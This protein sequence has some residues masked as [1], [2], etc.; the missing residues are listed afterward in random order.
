[1]Y[2]DSGR[3][4]RDPL[5]N[6]YWHQTS[7]DGGGSGAAGAAAVGALQDEVAELRGE[8]AAIRGDMQAILAKL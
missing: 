4:D 2:S 1:M 5:D 8:L 7:R 3:I 6:I